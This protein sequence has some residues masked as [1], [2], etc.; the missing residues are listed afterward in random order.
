MSKRKPL[1]ICVS[2]YFLVDWLT[3]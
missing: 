1:V 2:G 3:E